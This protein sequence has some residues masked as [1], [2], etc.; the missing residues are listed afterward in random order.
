MEIRINE[1]TLPDLLD[2]AFFQMM[3]SIQFDI[4]RGAAFDY[5]FG[6]FVAIRDFCLLLDRRDLHDYSN[7]QLATFLGDK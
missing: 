3:N 1:N 4:R 2:A 5:I 6:Q 7:A